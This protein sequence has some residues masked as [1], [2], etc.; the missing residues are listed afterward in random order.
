MCEPQDPIYY[1]A[2]AHSFDSTQVID[3]TRNWIDS[4]IFIFQFM[5]CALSSW[6]WTLRQRR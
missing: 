3:G 1:K 4:S 6:L 2:S 5:G